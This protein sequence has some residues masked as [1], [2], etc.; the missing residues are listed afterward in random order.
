VDFHIQDACI[1]IGAKVCFGG[2]CFQDEGA[3]FIA[4][5]LSQRFADDDLLMM[6]C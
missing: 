6:I 4:V 3:G 2:A 5:V 1:Q